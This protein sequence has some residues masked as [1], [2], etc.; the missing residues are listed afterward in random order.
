LSYHSFQWQKRRA[1]EKDKE[2]AIMKEKIYQQ[3]IVFKYDPQI[4]FP[5][6][7]LNQREFNDKFA[8]IPFVLSGYFDH[9]QEIKVKTPRLGN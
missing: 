5:W 8:Y 1:S 2:A 6:L 4:K 3:P 7:N 9:S